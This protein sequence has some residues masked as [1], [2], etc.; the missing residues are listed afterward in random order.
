M[1]EV[2][3][4]D[5]QEQILN[6]TAQL[7]SKYGIKS[8]TMD[9]ISRHLGISKKTLYQFVKDKNDL[10]EKV[11]MSEDSKLKKEFDKI[12]D[13]NKNA[14]D[15]LLEVHVFVN[16]IFKNYNPAKEYDLQKYH[17]EIYKKVYETRRHNMYKATLENIKKGQ[18]QGVYRKDLDAAIIAKLHVFR[19]ENIIEYD[20]FEVSEII[21]DHFCNEV[22]R[23]H[24][25]GMASEEG[26]KY[27]NEQLR[28]K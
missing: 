6:A 10:V 17:P 1:A 18:L 25:N 24:I 13:K 5:K 3:S 11:I 20:M 28:K 14:I 2:K 19:V 27:F 4:I 8:V 9:D 12:S 16:G 26:K 7:Y 15:E 23:Y 21:S 22:M